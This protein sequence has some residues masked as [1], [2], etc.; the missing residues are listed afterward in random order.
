MIRHIRGPVLHARTGELT[1]EVGG[2]G[3][4][5]FVMPDVPSRYTLGK[6]CRLWIYHAIRE[7]VSDLYGFETEDELLMYELLLAVPGIGPKS[8]LA[9]LALAPI[10][11]LRQA[12][13][14]GDAEY[15]TTVSGVGKKTAQKIV[16]ELKDKI[17]MSDDPS[18]GIG[19]DG[20]VMEALR[21]LGY[22]ADETRKVIAHLSNDIE[23]TSARVREALKLLSQ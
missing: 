20:D 5:V 17:G 19:A 21:A 22:S 16:L 23:G 4:R 3:Y 1:I 11:K 2:L 7:D 14:K 8:A 13:A 6:E 9:I 10:G 15:L 12:I 18:Y